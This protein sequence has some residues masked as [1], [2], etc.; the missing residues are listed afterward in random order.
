[1]KSFPSCRGETKTAAFVQGKRAFPITARRSA[2]VCRE[3]RVRHRHRQ[4]R[5]RTRAVAN[6]RVE[7]TAR[8]P[9]ST[10][11]ERSISISRTDEKA[12]ALVEPD[13]LRCALR[14][15]REKSEAEMEAINAGDVW[16]PCSTTCRPG[17]V[18][19]AR[20]AG[21]RQKARR[22]ADK[23]VENPDPGGRKAL[24]L[25]IVKVK[26]RLNGFALALLL[27]FCL[28]TKA[29]ARAFRRARGQLGHGLHIGGRAWDIMSGRRRR[30]LRLRDDHH[31]GGIRRH[32][33]AVSLEHISPDVPTFGDKADKQRLV[34]RRRRN[35]RRQRGR[36][37]TAPCSAPATP[38]RARRCRDARARAGLFDAGRFS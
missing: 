31:A 14:L 37:R 20:V 5:R 30:G 12:R 25:E 23:P 38:S 16:T 1:M 9:G 13:D 4:V 28:V 10:P 36:R 19:S 18:S 32:A 6:R 22:P 34:L 29:S 8:L 7:S 11:Q 24:K 27:A 17:L 3:R 21:R 35:G 26:R 2:V 33:A 15:L